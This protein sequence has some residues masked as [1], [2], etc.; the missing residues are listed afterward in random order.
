[1]EAVPNIV[2]SLIIWGVLLM[3]L[4]VIVGIVGLF[5]RRDNRWV[6]LVSRHALAGMFVAVFASILG[7]YFYSMILGFAPCVL[8]IYQR[9]LIIAQLIILTIAVARND[10]GVFPYV[11][12]L[13]IFG[14]L[15]AIYHVV[16][17]PIQAS[18]YICAP[19]AV[20]CLEGYVSGFGYITIPVMALTLF[21]FLI[22][23]WAY[24]MRV[25]KGGIVENVIK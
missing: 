15:I 18:S 13:S 23:L 1:M 4:A 11:G 12:G 16:I 9:W 10:R 6:V 14:F 22:V 20:S 25:S 8:C 24:G 3:Q 17:L 7:S 21:A 2:G 5:L 19:G